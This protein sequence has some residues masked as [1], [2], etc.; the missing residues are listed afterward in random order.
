MGAAV[1]KQ[2]SK[3]VDMAHYPHAADAESRGSMLFS[4]VSQIQAK[5][6]NMS[7]KGLFDCI[8]LKMLSRKVM[9]L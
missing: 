5:L 2:R 6:M 1:E 8:S 4:S 9:T 3:L 7:S